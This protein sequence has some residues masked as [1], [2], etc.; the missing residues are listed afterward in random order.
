MRGRGKLIEKW[1]HHKYDESANIYLDRETGSF[2]AEYGPKYIK[3]STLDGVRKQLTKIVEDTL[4]LDWFPVIEVSIR[5]KTHYAT[6]Q[7]LDRHLSKE[8]DS[9]VDKAETGEVDIDFNFKRFW[10]AKE[11]SGKW[12]H[13]DVWESLDFKGSDNFEPGTSKFGDP[14]PRRL[15]THE[16]HIY[17]H[18]L[19]NFSLPFSY[20]NNS[21]GENKPTHYVKYTPQL[22]AGLNEVAAKLDHLVTRLQ[23]L[24]ASEQG[25]KL[26]EGLVQKLLPGGTHGGS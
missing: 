10:M 11:P 14:L 1:K 6:N 15:N 4:V 20:Q 3:E 8:E 25:L 7:P 5:S 17:G 16:F 13:C 21:W 26:V 2:S 12:L 9:D 19:K 22:W 18:D 24:I 23:E